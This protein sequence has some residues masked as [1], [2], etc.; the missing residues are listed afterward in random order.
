MIFAQLISIK[1]KIMRTALAFGTNLNLIVI[2]P[3][4]HS[5]AYIQKYIKGG[6]GFLEFFYKYEILLKRCVTLKNYKDGV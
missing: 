4:N 6:V 3:E 1:N 5:Y 2:L